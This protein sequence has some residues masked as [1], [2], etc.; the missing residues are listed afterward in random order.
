MPARRSGLP[1]SWPPGTTYST[2]TACQSY[3]STMGSW[4]PE[5][6]VSMLSGKRHRQMETNGATV[7]ISGAMFW[8]DNEAVAASTWTS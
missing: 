2:A 8:R 4:S 7:S 5:R 3:S 1:V 6:H